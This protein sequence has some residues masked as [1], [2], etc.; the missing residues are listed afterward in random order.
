M[1]RILF[2]LFL[3]FL[4]CDKNNI[5]PGPDDATHKLLIETD[6]MAY[7][8][9]PSE[10]GFSIVMY[11]M[12]TNETD[13]VFY[14]KI[15]DLFSGDMPC[16]FV[17]NSGAYLEKYNPVEKQ[18]EIKNITALAFEGTKLVPLQPSQ[19]YSF[20]SYLFTNSD[21]DETGTYRFRLDYFIQEDPDSSITPY[22]DYSNE[23]EL[24][25]E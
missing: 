5:P 19:N 24:K 7:T 15:G 11:G 6:S 25:T 18:W 21:Q 8:W 22:F 9:Q 2:L 23:F 4:H 14:S 17:R 13:T 12:L 20:S 16:C 3:I 10:S 1:K